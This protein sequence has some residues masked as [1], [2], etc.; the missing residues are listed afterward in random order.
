MSTLPW[1]Y[2]SPLQT[3]RNIGFDF[4]MVGFAIVGFANTDRLL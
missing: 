2:S 1:M 4:A 3:T